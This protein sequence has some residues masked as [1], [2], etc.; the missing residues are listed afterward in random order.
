MAQIEI[1]QVRNVYL[2]WR[3][4]GRRALPMELRRSILELAAVYGDKLVVEK[5]G[6]SSASLWQWR[7]GMGKAAKRSTAKAKPIQFVEV[8]AVPESKPSPGIVIEWQRSDGHQM[9]VSGLSSSGE[10]Q[11]LVRTFLGGAA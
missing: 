1:N 9:R 7:Q 11:G 2:G 3:K 6:V 10:I 4:G 5:L 8:K